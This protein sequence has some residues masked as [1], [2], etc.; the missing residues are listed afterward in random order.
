MWDQLFAVTNLAAVIGW[1][2]L[3]VDLILTLHKDG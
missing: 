3:V 1:T 2:A